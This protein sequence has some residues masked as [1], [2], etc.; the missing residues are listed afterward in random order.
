MEHLKELWLVAIG[1]FGSFLSLV[2][3]DQPA[4]RKQGW[5]MLVA[6]TGIAYFSAPLVM[7]YLH[8]NDQFIGGVIFLTGIFGRAVVQAMINS[9]PDL[10]KTRLKGEQE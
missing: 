4:D 8:I 3:G 7:H 6:G 9:I 1:G 10:I 5:W 2:L